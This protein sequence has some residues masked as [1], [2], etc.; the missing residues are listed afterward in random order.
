MIVTE[1]DSQWQALNFTSPK[2]DWCSLSE[3]CWV[4]FPGAGE[5]DQ[6]ISPSV[7]G[8]VGTPGSGP[9]QLDGRNESR[10]YVMSLYLP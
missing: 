4:T 1:W 5:G 10:D 3:L 8:N 7:P 9:E 6:S 2:E